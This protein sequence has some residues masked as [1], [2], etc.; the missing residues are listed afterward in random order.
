VVA[1]CDIRS[2]SIRGSAA[3]IMLNPAS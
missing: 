3:L 1:L 2:C